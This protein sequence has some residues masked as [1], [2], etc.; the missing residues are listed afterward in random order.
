MNIA[1]F[2]AG[3]EKL[4][5]EIHSISE[6][7]AREATSREADKIR[8]VFGIDL[9]VFGVSVSDTKEHYHFEGHTHDAHHS[10]SHKHAV[11]E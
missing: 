2:M 3:G 9:S 6:G 11:T 1:I 7:A 4:K 10:H 5:S 8:R